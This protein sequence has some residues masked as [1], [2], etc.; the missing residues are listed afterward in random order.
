MDR[1]QSRL[2]QLFGWKKCTHIF[3][4]I[5]CNFS[6][7][8]TLDP[9]DHFCVFFFLHQLHLFVGVCVCVG[10]NF[11]LFLA[12]RC[13]EMRPISCLQSHDWLSSHSW[14][15][16]RREVLSKRGPVPQL[17]VSLTCA[18]ARLCVCGQLLISD[19]NSIGFDGGT[20]ARVSTHPWSLPKGVKS[21]TRLHAYT[22]ST[23]LLPQKKEGGACVGL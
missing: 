9:T 21:R 17:A 19:A 13:E 15:R 16:N 20:R 7:F 11:P 10:G 14:I 12:C 2:G 22:H 6:H 4:R 5:L 3:Q 8:S 23:L 18:C 1:E